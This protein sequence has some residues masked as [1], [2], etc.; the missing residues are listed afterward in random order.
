MQTIKTL[1][2]ICFGLSLI[3]VPNLGSAK[4]EQVNLTPPTLNVP[5]PGL[6]QWAA[7]EASTGEEF[8]VPWM[9]E[10]ILALYR[11]GVILGVTLAVLILMAGGIIY[12]SSAGNDTRIKKA[13]S[14]MFGSLSGLIVLLGS[15]L[16]LYMTNPNNIELNP[17]SVDAIENLDENVTYGKSLLGG[18]SGVCKPPK[19]S[20]LEYCGI[21]TSKA[22]HPDYNGLIQKMKDY[23]A[24]GDFNWKILQ[25]MCEH[26]SSFRPGLVNCACF[27]GLY[28]FKKKSWNYSVGGEAKGSYYLGKLG[29]DSSPMQVNDLRLFND[30]VQILGITKA[31]LKAINSI[32]SHCKDTSKLSDSDVATLLYL[33][34]NSGPGSLSNTLNFGGCAGGDSIREGLT[35]SWQ[36]IIVKRCKENAF[37]KGKSECTAGDGGYQNS[38][39]TGG[40]Y[41]SVAEAEAGGKMFGEGK[42]VSVRKAGEQRIINKYGAENLLIAEPGAGTCPI[43]GF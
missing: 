41:K 29:L 19:N 15:Y 20:V 10:Y 36:A 18:E 12:V 4:V 42:A 17:L 28:Q 2:L 23:A 39:W 5:L 11:Y 22:A 21:T 26:E 40:N 1:I 37:D 8:S 6:D 13:K 24:C 27:K 34:H 3:L 9:V 16:I 14:M 33:F 31:T 7:Q 38:K 43:S 35:K 30:D 25:G 32:K